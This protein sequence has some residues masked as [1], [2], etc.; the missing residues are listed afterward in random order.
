LYQISTTTSTSGRRLLGVPQSVKTASSNET[1]TDTNSTNTTETDSDETSS[2]RDSTESVEESNSTDTAGDEP[3]IEENNTLSN[4][5]N[6][7]ETDS[8]ETDNLHVVSLD[9]NTTSDLSSSEADLNDTTSSSENSDSSQ[10]NNTSEEANDINNDTL[11]IVDLNETGSGEL[12]D[13]SSEGVSEEGLASEEGN[14]T[15]TNA[16]GMMTPPSTG[17]A[18]SSGN[19]TTS[20]GNATTSGNAT[21]AQKHQLCFDVPAAPKNRT[22]VACSSKKSTP[23][24]LPRAWMLMNNLNPDT[25]DVCKSWKPAVGSKSVGCVNV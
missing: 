12:E 22:D 16:T 14:E 1:D 19:A 2:E 18:T 7:P 10:L 24:A 3:L 15:T 5:A 13:V 17:N 20:T 23:I 11:R 9:N 21:T 4:D 8:N 25:A 6:S